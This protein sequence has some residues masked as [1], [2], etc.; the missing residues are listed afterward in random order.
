MKLPC[1]LLLLIIGRVNG[2]GSWIVD[3]EDLA[4]LRTAAGTNPSVYFEG[5]ASDRS[6]TALVIAMDDAAS[7]EGL[8]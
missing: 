5:D 7:D 8:D 3:E 6:G 1:S 4:S 2:G